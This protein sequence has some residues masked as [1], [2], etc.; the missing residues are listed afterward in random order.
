MPR[1]C[2]DFAGG[3]SLRTLRPA[4]VDHQGRRCYY[5][6]EQR[7]PERC[8]QAGGDQEAAAQLAAA[9]EQRERV[10]FVNSVAADFQGNPELVAFALSRS[11]GVDGDG[12]G[13]RSEW[14][15]PDDGGGGPHVSLP[16]LSAGQIPQARAGVKQRE[17]P[18]VSRDAGRG[19]RL[20]SSL[21]LPFDPVR[22]KGRRGGRQ[23]DGDDRPA[24]SPSR[25]PARLPRKSSMTEFTNPT[26]VCRS[27]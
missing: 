18:C 24:D 12:R 16:T 1:N 9:G 2:A 5:R 19:E 4:Q 22:G 21:L 26:R 14:N 6:G 27:G 8:H 11:A 25:T 10:G 13:A 15:V 23:Y 20:E 3:L 7:R 17:R